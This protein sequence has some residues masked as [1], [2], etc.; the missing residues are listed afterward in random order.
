M[1]ADWIDE[2][3]AAHGTGMQPDEAMA[4]VRESIGL[5]FSKVLENAGVFKMT[6]EGKAAFVRFLA[7]IGCETV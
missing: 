7:S 6:D 4:A 3:V 1:H 5:K 2:L